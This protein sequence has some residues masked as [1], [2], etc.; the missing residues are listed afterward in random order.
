MA[1]A[2]YIHL[3]LAYVENREHEFT[4]DQLRELQDRGCIRCGAQMPPEP[5]DEERKRIFDDPDYEWPRPD[6][7]YLEP[8]F[9]LMGGGYGHYLSCDGCGFFAK[10]DL[11]PEAE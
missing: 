1:T 5:S 6:G 11:G 9:G 10:H 7:V 4:I 3:D 2:G 8:G